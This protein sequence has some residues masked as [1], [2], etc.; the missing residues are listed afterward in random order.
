LAGPNG[1]GKSNLLEVLASI[2]YHLECM[3]LDYRPD[4]FEYNEETKP[5]GFQ[6]AVSTPDAFELE[7][8]IQN[9]E[10]DYYTP[11]VAGLAVTGRTMAGASD[12]S[13]RIQVYKIRIIK[14]TGK[15]PEFRRI[16]SETGEEIELSGKQEIKKILPD[17]I[18]GYSSGENEIVSLPFYKMRFIH[19]DEY[20]SILI[21][22]DFYGQVPEGRLV[23]LDEHLNQSILLANF[24]MQ[25]KSDL[26]IIS[27]ELELSDIKQ[28]QII[29][30]KHHFET[31]HDDLLNDLS[32]ED[33]SNESKTKIELTDKLS[34]TINRLK[35]CSTTFYESYDEDGNAQLLILDFFV[36][37]ETKKAFRFHFE[38][39]PLKLFQA[40]QILYTLNYAIIST[41]NREKIYSTQNIYLKQDLTSIS[42]DENS[43]FRIKDL[44]LQKGNLSED[45]F[46][47]SL[48]DGEYQ[49]LH[50]I[51]LCLLYRDTN[52]L[53]LLDEPETH[54]NPDW[55]AKFI[56]L[57]KKAFEESDS[58][59]DLLIT[60]HTPY[61]ISDSKRENVLVFEKKDDTCTVT[62]PDYNT[63]GA[64]INKITMMTFKKNVTMGSLAES[65]LNKISIRSEKGESSEELIEELNSALGDSVEKVL[66]MKSLSEK[67]ES[68]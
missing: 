27:E 46:T 45:I 57:L 17:F 56:T 39:S 42:L 52:S 38:D 29:I 40:L 19:F 35:S 59:Q 63:F 41:M 48:S 12:Y 68:E 65:V 58:S 49:L 51:G 66:L 15:S 64:S 18:L 21:R 36:T 14:K 10:Q 50:S 5:Q 31:L 2:F 13:D 3:Y 8:L 6:G 33:L 60:T 1:S 9:I 37:E 55:R 22:D 43:I 24:L 23:Y 28:F 4:S 20:R 11:A 30:R 47:R 44:K 7:Y 67:G 61:L 25:K 16:D 53:F 54:F 62:R 34:E 26:S 32:S